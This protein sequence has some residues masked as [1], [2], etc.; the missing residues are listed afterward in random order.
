MPIGSSNP[1]M[2]YKARVENQDWRLTVLEKKDTD[3]YKVEGNLFFSDRKSGESWYVDKDMH[4]SNYESM[5]DAFS[6]CRVLNEDNKATNAYEKS[7]EY[8]T[9]R[10]RTLPNNV[11]PRIK[12]SSSLEDNNVAPS[13][14]SF[15]QAKMN[16]RTK[17][18]DENLDK[19][20]DDLE[21]DE[22]RNLV[23]EEYKKL[24]NDAYEE[25]KDSQN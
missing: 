20:L 14:S 24:N 19:A 23:A 3:K 11:L 22:P 12:E 9:L 16:I 8:E 10:T 17:K 25:N 1:V 21:R 18:V 4:E 15:L 6:L 5:R 2:I 13:T 7:N